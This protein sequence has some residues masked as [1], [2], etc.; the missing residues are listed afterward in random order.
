MPIFGKVA[1]AA[2]MT[3]APLLAWRFVIA[4][5]VFALIATPK[6]KGLALATGS[7]SGESGSCSS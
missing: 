5:L 6:S 1:Y 2:G 7:A 4:T 3:A